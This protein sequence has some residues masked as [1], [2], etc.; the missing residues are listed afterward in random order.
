MVIKKTYKVV[1]EDGFGIRI[2]H[3]KK[4]AEYFINERPEFVIQVIRTEVE[5]AYE[6]GLRLCGEC[7][8]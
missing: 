8:L 7:L 4:D 2:F 1:D 5:S 6:K 3:G